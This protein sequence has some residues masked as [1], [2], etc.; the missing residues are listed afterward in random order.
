MVIF[1]TVIVVI[2]TIYSI[3]LGFLE[4]N[5][6]KQILFLCFLVVFHTILV[7]CTLV[8]GNGDFLIISIFFTFIL[9]LVVG[10]VPE[11]YK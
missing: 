2:L 3:V 11:K 5:Q 10:F 4:S 8:T 1:F 9:L 7:G 6:I